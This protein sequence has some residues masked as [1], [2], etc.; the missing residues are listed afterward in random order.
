MIRD[1]GSEVFCCLH[2]MRISLLILFA[3]ISIPG[4][5]QVQD[6]EGF[7]LVK[8]EPPIEVHERWVE[9]PNKKPIVTS[10]ELKTEFT[11]HAPIHKIIRIIKDESHVKTWQEHVRD[12]KI[13]LKTDTTVW[14]EYSCHDIPW[15]LSDQDSFL[16][17][18]L[19]ETVPGK[20]YIVGF[21][22]RIDKTVAPVYNNINR[23]E[24]VGSWKFVLL[25]PGVA[26][27]TYRVQSAS[28]VNIPRMIV[29]PV[30]RNNLVET[31]RLL[32]EI[33]EK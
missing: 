17:Y 2:S 23:I 11:V 32:T 8:S 16:E 6:K 22:S 33:A 3:A 10:R 4:F 28:P 7:I 18:K 13:Y 19:T 21:K 12:Y 15:P 9:F 31:I 26:R 29:D 30:I 1:E 20:E 25:S 5:C 27:V 14:E 24:L